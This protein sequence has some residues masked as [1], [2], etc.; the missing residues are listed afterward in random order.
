MRDK[1]RLTAFASTRQVSAPTQDEG[2]GGLDLF[3]LRDSGTVAV[4]YGGLNATSRL[5]DQPSLL[6]AALRTSLD[7]YR[8]ANGFTFCPL[9]QPT[10]APYVPASRDPM[11]RA[12]TWTRMAKALCATGT[13]L[14]DPTEAFRPGR[15]RDL[16]LEAGVAAATGGPPSG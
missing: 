14:H 3:A 13:F 11:K 16:P 9:R 8:T 6:A 1:E 4:I 7:A 12:C 10:A 2:L 5:G 15:S